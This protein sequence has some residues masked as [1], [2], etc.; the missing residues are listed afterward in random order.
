[1]EDMCFKR[2]PRCGGEL[3]YGRI[4]VS[5]SRKIGILN[6]FTEEINFYPEEDAEYIKNRPV[7]SIFTGAERKTTRVAAFKQPCIPAA[8]CEDC[9]RIFAEIEMRDSYNPIGEATLP[10]YDEDYYCDENDSQ[11]DDKNIYVQEEDPYEE[12][13]GLIEWD[14]SDDK[15]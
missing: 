5:A 11:I 6:N 7:K 12:W 8:Y 9:D 2:C 4:S 1:M 13:N 10:T 3:Q 14:S 15:E